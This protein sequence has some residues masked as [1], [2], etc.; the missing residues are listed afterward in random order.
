MRRIRRFEAYVVYRSSS[1]EEREETFPV[2]VEDYEVAKTLTLKYILQVLKLKDF[3]LRL[4][5]G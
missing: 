1:G 3:E 5:G 4:V 2:Q